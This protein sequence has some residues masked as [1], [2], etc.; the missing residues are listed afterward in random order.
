MPEEYVDR[1]TFN[2]GDLAPYHGS[3]ELRSILFEEGETE[4]YSGTQQVDQDNMH[5]NVTYDTHDDPQN[6]KSFCESKAIH[7]SA[8]EKRPFDSP[9]QTLWDSH[10]GP[11]TKLFTKQPNTQHSQQQLMTQNQDNGK[12]EVNNRGQACGAAWTEAGA[13][14]ESMESFT[15]HGPFKAQAFI[16]S[17]AQAHNSSPEQA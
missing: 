1:N 3:Q 15:I 8:R 17:Q 10:Q 2:I 5:T 12:T 11:R 7:H 4:L 9:T 13:L 6:S 14:E 16:S